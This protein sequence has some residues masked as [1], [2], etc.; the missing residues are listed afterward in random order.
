MANS[1]SV[2]IELAKTVRMSA[3]EKEEQRR[4]FAYGNTA[5][6]NRRISRSLV[7]EQADKIERELKTA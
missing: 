6:E 7:D 4:S 5:I 1:I 2:L 3:G